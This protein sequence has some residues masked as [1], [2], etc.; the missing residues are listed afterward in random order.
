[1]RI[2]MKIAESDS[3]C[4]LVCISKLKKKTMFD[5]EFISSVLYETQ[6]LETGTKVPYGKL[7]KCPKV[8]KVPYGT[9][10]KCPNVTK[11]P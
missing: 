6:K 9:L 3:A 2:S 4:R 1:M 8:T 10:H 11:V 5:L 7:H